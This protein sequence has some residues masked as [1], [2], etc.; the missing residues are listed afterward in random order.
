M[1][2]AYRTQ[3]IRTICEKQL[4]AEETL[5]IKTAS[6]LRARLEDINSAKC[7]SD[8]IAGSPKELE[9]GVIQ[10][11]LGNGHILKI[12]SNHPK[13]PLRKDKKLDWDR[14]K[15]IQILEIGETNA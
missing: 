9:N 5:G 11:N 15:R 7:L 10:V 3:K 2:I 12:K 6:Y 4:I 1:K 14:V 13:K 8:L